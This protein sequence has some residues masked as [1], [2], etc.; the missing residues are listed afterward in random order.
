MIAHQEQ[1]VLV[2][3]DRHGCNHGIE[4]DRGAIFPQVEFAAASVWCALL[5]EVVNVRDAGTPSSPAPAIRAAQENF[6]RGTARSVRASG[7]KSRTKTTSHE[8]RASDCVG[9]LKLLSR[10]PAHVWFSLPSSRRSCRSVVQRGSKSRH[11]CASFSVRACGGCVRVR[12]GQ[13]D[14][15]ADPDE[16]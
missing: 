13:T 5:L 16:R 15:R 4:M 9:S 14:V 10:L 11:A 12:S 3:A 7:D 1:C 2:G 6:C 8:S